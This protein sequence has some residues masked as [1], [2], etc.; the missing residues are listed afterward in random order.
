[1]NLPRFSVR[2][3]VAVNLLMVAIVVG[4]LVAWMTLVREFFPTMESEQLLITV[5][6]P[7]ATPEEIE[8]SVTRIVER[9]V[10][11]VEGIEEIRSRV[12]EGITLIQIQLEDGV[13]RDRALRDVRAELDKA[14]PELPEAAEEPE[15]AESRPYIPAIALVLHG[16]VSER[17][18]REVVDDVRDDLLDMPEVT[19]VVV[20]GIRK[21]EFVVEVRP[22]LLE[23]QGLTIDD[24]GNTLRMLNRDVPGG[25]LKG[26]TSNVRVR[27]MGE[28]RV[29]H[30]LEDLAVRTEAGGATLRLGELGRARAA[31]EDKTEFGRWEGRRSAAINV[32]KTPEQDAI[33]IAEAV[34]QY[35]RE[36][37]TRLG[38]AV[39]VEVTTDLSRIIEG[40]LDLMTRNA[41]AGLI[42]VLLV[43]AL[44]LEVRVAFWVAVGLGVAFMG[45]FILMGAF[46]QSVNLI[47]LFGLIVVLGLIVDDAIVIAENIF[48]RQR[49]GE[50]PRTAAILGAGRVGLPVV[51]AVMTTIAA[52]APLMFMEGRIGSFL[53]VLPIVVIMALFVS[54]IEGFL[55]LPAHLAHR[56][57]E[58]KGRTAFG[59]F[60]EAGR[61]ARH[62]FFEQTMPNALG[63]ALGFL[64]RWRYVTIAACFALLMTAAGFVAGGVVPFVLLQNVDAETI[65]AKLEMA[66]GTP[67]SETAAMLDRVAAVAAQEPEVKTVFSVLGASFSQRGR[68]TPADPAVVG[69][70][71]IEL[72][73]ADVREAKGQRKSTELLSDLR[74]KTGNLPGVRRLSYISQGGG[75]GGPDLEI[76]LR[77]DDLDMISRAVDHVEERAKNYVGVEEIYN[78]LERGKLEARFRLRDDARLT[79][80]TTSGVAMQLRNALFG[81]EVQDLQIGNDDVTVRVMLPEEDR[82]DLDDLGT[83]RLSTP[84]G[85]RIPLEEAAEFGTTR[86]YASIVRVDGKRAVTVTAQVD[87]TRGNT[88]EITAALTKE[89]A[90][91]GDRFPGVSLSFEGRRKDT[92]ESVGS[93]KILFPIALGLIF[94]I[95]AVLFRSYVQP[96]I[97]MSVIPF[98]LIGVVFGHALMGYP[99]TILSM[100]GMVALAG[101]VVNDGLILVDL[102]NRFRRKGFGVIESVRR[103][104]MGRMRAILLTSIT[105]CVGLAPL[106]LETSFQAQFLI[107]MAVSIVFGLAFATV[108]VLLLLP[109]FY[110]A[111]EDV[112]A[113]LRWLASGRWHRSLPYDPALAMDDPKR[114]HK[115]SFI[116][117]P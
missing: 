83:L 12:F 100:I 35:Q 43:L 11:D 52:F 64:L 13:D 4:G 39:T 61:Q 88:A 8:R 27:T 95:I 44:F 62:K 7:G 113:G 77:G 69:Q 66:A 68:D 15:L 63:K 74:I 89:L 98:S 59:R 72:Q 112:R 1:M 86:G 93:L 102:A 71:T 42:L 32:F 26:R 67:E 38:G 110:V 91:I 103:A 76:R 6:Y 48:A 37:P 28:E 55:I 2:N 99:F 81:Y 14:K 117:D 22:E 40:R 54:L 111:L 79:G 45:T 85:A 57:K 116:P 17:Q 20:T 9:E 114:T 30:H 84:S 33:K 109:C 80:L 94:C 41:Q 18:L 106:M 29:P 5:A 107:P 65:T 53:G 58:G 70:V 10:E 92:R 19:E 105:T 46:G 101:I 31:F 25:Q 73:G 115:V 16:A 96:V 23:E 34:R 3:P 108:L 75:P 56:S 78:D 87:E 51:A 50:D 60:I 104:A 24:V 21:R 47:S 36:H 82:E 97:V 49:T 90:D